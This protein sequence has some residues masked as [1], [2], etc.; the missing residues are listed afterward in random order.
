MITIETA[1][2]AALMLAH[3][4]ES[5][6][7]WHCRCWSSWMYWQAQTHPPPLGASTLVPVGMVISVTQ[8]GAIWLPSLDWEWELAGLS[9]LLKALRALTWTWFNL[10]HTPIAT[11][12][13]I[14]MCFQQQVGSRFVT[15]FSATHGPLV[16]VWKQ[17]TWANDSPWAHSSPTAHKEYL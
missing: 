9:L 12:A 11:A 13:D 3:V 16:C 2:P 17:V 10:Y 6:G 14:L 8:K 15:F 5:P 4:S 7:D 1:N